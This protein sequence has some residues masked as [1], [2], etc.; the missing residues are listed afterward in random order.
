M[1]EKSGKVF[2]S[3]WILSDITGIHQAAN[4]PGT[5]HI[6]LLS[7]SV[8]VYSTG[9]LVEEAQKLGLQVILADPSNCSVK[10]GWG[11]PRILM[12]AKDITH[13]FQAIIPRIGTQLTPHG[14]AIVAQ[15]EMNGV[16]STARSAG[17][18]RAGNKVQTLQLL[19]GRGIAI[20]KT[21]FSINPDTIE[22]Q[23]A[24]LGGA[25]LIIKL[26][27]GTQ[28]LGVVLAESVR[29][30][31][32]IAD[33]FYKM[34]T[35]VLLQEYI[36]ESGGTDIRIL[37]VGDRVVASME[38][39]SALG[40]FR[41]NMHRGGHAQR[42]DPRPEELQMALQAARYLGLGVAG[43]DLI[44]SDRGPLLIEVNASPGFKGMEEVTG[45]NVA[46][47][48]LSYVMQ[49]VEGKIAPL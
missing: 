30:A 11:G 6:G 5:M 41:S 23:I 2:G 9:R 13:A 20:P 15:F 25:P 38:R 43:V 10:L 42:V 24:L 29:S 46:G 28:G 14:A 21:L 12:G 39:C 31:K 1:V 36:A 18:L 19:S 48:I 49:A 45:V 17:I 47:A 7:T 22:A 37:V 40:E 27:E 8:N 44:R 34:H 32:S 16:F 26:Q 33:T 3:S 4:T 35:P